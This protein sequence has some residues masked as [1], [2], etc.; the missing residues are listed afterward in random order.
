[1]QHA[2]GKCCRIFKA[3]DIAVVDH[4]MAMFYHNLWSGQLDCLINNKAINDDGT[5][6]IYIK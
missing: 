5:K 4:M 1:M 6:Q 2:P 3:V